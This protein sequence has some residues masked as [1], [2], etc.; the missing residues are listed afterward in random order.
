MNHTKCSQTRLQN[1]EKISLVTLVGGAEQQPLPKLHPHPPPLTP[2]L[3]RETAGTR[4]TTLFLGHCWKSIQATEKERGTWSSASGE[5]ARTWTK[6]STL[7]EQGRAGALGKAPPLWV[8]GSLCLR[9]RLNQNIR[10]HFLPPPPTAVLTASGDYSSGM[11]VE[12]YIF[13]GEKKVR[14]RPLGFS[15]PSK[16]RN[17]KAVQQIANPA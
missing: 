9:I 13:S 4:S 16:C 14:R 2:L 15:T 8:P 6:Q 3:G 1:S 12:G 5:G 7:L 11:Q 17:S 10:E